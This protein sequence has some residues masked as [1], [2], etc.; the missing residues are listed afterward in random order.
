MQRCY[1]HPSDGRRAAPVPASE[2][3]KLVELPM[4]AAVLPK[5]SRWNI[6]A[7]S[8]RLK[9]WPGVPD[10]EGADRLELMPAAISAD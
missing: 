9:T 5:L 2:P 7:V 8:A 10:S 4:V 1:T 6:L 3:P